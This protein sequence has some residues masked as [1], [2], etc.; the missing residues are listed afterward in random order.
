MLEYPSLRSF[1]EIVAFN[2]SGLVVTKP[3][4]AVAGDIL[5][6][7][8]F[9]SGTP[10][11]LA[12]PDSLWIDCA[13]GAASGVCGIWVRKLTPADNSTVSWTFTQA[14]T[15]DS[16]NICVCWK[17]AGDFRIL[18]F[19]RPSSTPVN[20]GDFSSSIPNSLLLSIGEIDAAPLSIPTGFTE[21]VPGGSSGFLEQTYRVLPS[22]N[23]SLNIT[24]S[25]TGGAQMLALT[26]IILYPQ[27]DYNFYPSVPSG[28]FVRKQLIGA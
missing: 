22:P 28:I 9:G 12:A 13:N 18:N 25:L 1:T 23:D 8:I 11:T 10:N 24:W 4:G 26:T 20:L 2:P 17:N 27:V 6:A 16:A 19:Q 15:A 5:T 14:G 3:A 7:L 21:V